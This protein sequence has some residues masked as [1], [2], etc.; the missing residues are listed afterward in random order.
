MRRGTGATAIPR[1]PAAQ[2]F[3]GLKYSPEKANRRPSGDHTAWFAFNL[4]TDFFSA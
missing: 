2:D 4:P 1:H 3:A